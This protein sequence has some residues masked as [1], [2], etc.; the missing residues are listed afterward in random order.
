M[1][2]VHKTTEEI[3]AMET[4]GD[5]A[6]CLQRSVGRLAAKPTFKWRDK[7]GWPVE[8]IIGRPVTN[9]I[10]LLIH[11]NIRQSWRLRHSDD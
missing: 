3:E 8:L 4:R 10:R 2:E 9:A 1:C 7:Y 5:S 11:I 6:D